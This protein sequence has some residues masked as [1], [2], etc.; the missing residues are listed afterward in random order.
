MT[1]L[2]IIIDN[3]ET[4]IIKNI[5]NNLQFDKE[6]LDIGDIII[7]NDNIELI[8][9]RKT[10]CDLWASI[11]DGR[12]KEQKIRLIDYKQKNTNVYLCYLIENDNFD[13]DFDILNGFK[14]N[15]M[16]RD[17]I[18]IIETSNLLHTVSIIEKIIKN[19]N[20]FSSNFIENNKYFSNIK[21]KKGDNLTKDICYINQLSQI[22]G[23]SKKIAEFIAS[24][25]PSMPLLINHLQE[26]SY[27]LLANL[28]INGR[29]IGKKAET[30]YN[31]LL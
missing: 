29:K 30:I 4:K 22:P 12:Y 2:K 21:T 11:K 15:S 18:Y 13:I 25:Y 5:N 20:K 17:N 24:N 31:F 1:S 8:I 10:L 6:N 26:N 3:R 23:I 7:K 14:I 16:F 9:E 19:F 27:N 28:K